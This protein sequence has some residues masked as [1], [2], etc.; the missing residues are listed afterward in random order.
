MAEQGGDQGAQGQPSGQPSGPWTG[1]GPEDMALVQDRHWNG[2]G[3]VLRSYRN[4]E[5][6]RGVPDSE[7]LRIPRADDAAGWDAF[8]GRLRP[9]GPDKYDLGEHAPK[10]GQA[11]LR[12]LAHKFGLTQRQAAGLAAELAQITA[13]HTEQQVAERGQRAEADVAALRQSWGPEYD[14]NIAAGQ[15]AKQALGWDDATLDKLEDALGL[16]GTLE[17]AARIGRGLKEDGFAGPQGPQAG[18][19]MPFGLTRE[20]A[21]SQLKALEG[22]ADW[23]KRR[24]SNN[25]QIRTEAMEERARLSR[26]ANPD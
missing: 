4:L 22:N 12:P 13:G 25:M 9:E 15:R 21:A 17:L 18:G 24:W 19:S 8:H 14:A 1:L 3:E 23:I 26:I 20:V 6:L 5:K 10:E 11:D 16:R 2:V 7:L